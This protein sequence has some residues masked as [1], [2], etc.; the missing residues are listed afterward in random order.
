[1]VHGLHRFADTPEAFHRNDVPIINQRCINIR[2]QCL[3]PFHIGLAF[4]ELLADARVDNQ[5]AQWK[6]VE[7]WDDSLYLVGAIIAQT[8]FHTEFHVVD[9]LEN[10]FK[11][12]CHQVGVRQE[13]A[14][15]F[16]VGHA[17]E[18]TAHVQIDFLVAQL[19]ALLGEAQNLFCVG[20]E[21]LWRQ[22]LHIVAR[23]VDFLHLQVL[24]V[25]FLDAREE[26]GVELVNPSEMLFEHV[27][28]GCIGDA[29]EGP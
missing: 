23:R 4:V 29:L 1:M 8:A 18:R 11:H 14:T 5:F 22:G 28:E 15:T 25:V 10:S 20:A 16:L 19:L 13:A 6:T 24:R 21:D 3:E 26:G 17:R 9:A 7:Y 2:Y 12:R 27:A